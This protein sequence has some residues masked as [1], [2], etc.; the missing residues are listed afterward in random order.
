M[1]EYERRNGIKID[2]SFIDMESGKDFNRKEYRKMYKKLKE[3][4]LII[5]KSIDR[6]GRNYNDIREEWRKITQ[7]KKADMIVLDMP[8][9]DTTKNKDL[10]GTLI[11]ELVFQILSFVA[12][13]ER[14]SIKQRQAEG[15]DAAKKRGVKFGRPKFESE[16]YEEI[17]KRFQA[18]EITQKEAMKQ[19]KVS[20][21]T[22][23][24]IVHDI[25]AKQK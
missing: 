20:K 7:E 18:G 13:N 21:N 19:M 9:L 12:E 2:K 1:E 17:Y 5:V 10:V 24:R 3:G 23:Y 8:M 14:L 6:L 11:S 15:I 22:Y 4:D 25:E 16:E